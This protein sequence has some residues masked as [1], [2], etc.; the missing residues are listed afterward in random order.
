MSSRFLAASL[1][2]LACVLAACGRETRNSRGQPLPETANA[3]IETTTLFAGQPEP[4]PPDPRAAAY[5]KNAYNLSEGGRLYRW[6]NCV[7]CHS[8]GGGGM[9]PSLMDDEWRY[10]GRI[11][12]IVATILQG[13]PNGM[14]SFRGKLTE[15]QVWQ[16]AAYVRSLS[17]QAPKDA[18]SSR[19]DEMSNIEPATLADKEPLRPSDA[20]PAT[21]T[22][23]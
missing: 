23:Q 12:Q 13:R 11:E 21:G 9:G 22:V 20:A 5:E 8:H 10:G 4:T 17:G 15:Q 6:M 3:P 16:L 18:V 14:P 19:Y 2:A 7:G 1:L